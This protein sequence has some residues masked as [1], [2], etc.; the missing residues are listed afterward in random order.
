MLKNIIE[1][2]GKAVFT[3][4][5]SYKTPHVLKTPEQAI[6]G[7]IDFEYQQDIDRLISVQLSIE[8][9]TEIF[10]ISESESKTFGID[11]LRV[12]ILQTLDKN[13]I[14]YKSGKKVKHLYLASYYSTAELSQLK[15]FWN[16]CSVRNVTPKI[17]NVSFPLIERKSKEGVVRGKGRFL[18]SII[19]VYHFFV[20]M[21]TETGKKS[22]EAVANEF[23]ETKELGG[24]MTLEGVGG[25]T[26][27]YWKSHMLEFK[28]KHPVEF[29]KYAL[30]D[31]IITEALL[32]AYR[33]KEWEEL[34]VDL[35]QAPTNGAIA[36]TFFRS[37]EMKEGLKYGNTN[38][39]ARKFILEC[40]HG[41][42]M[43][44]LKRGL[45]ESIFENDAK[46]FYSYSM[47]N[48]KLLPRN[49]E[50]IV[51]A[52]TLKELLTGYDGWCKVKFKFPN[53]F[54]GKKVFPTLPIQKYMPLKDGKTGK[55][56]SLILFPRTGVSYCTVSEIRGAMEFGCKIEFIEGWYYVDGTD[57]FSDFAGKEIALR[58]KARA[59]GDKIGE[60]IHKSLPNHLVGKLFQHRGGFE[61]E[62]AQDIA[63]YLEE[64]LDRVIS[65]KAAVSI[66]CIEE[67]IKE[68]MEKGLEGKAHNERN[69]RK[70]KRKDTR[71]ALCLRIKKN[72]VE[73]T[74]KTRIGACWL[75]EIW[76]LILG[77]A[78]AAL[79][80]V[81]NK[82][83][84]DPVHISTD[85][86]HDVVPLNAEIETPFGMYIFE[87]TGKEGKEMC[88]D[89]TKL[90]TH[91]EKIAQHAVHVNDKPF[92]R[93]MIKD[94][95]KTTY[96][97]TGSNTLRSAALK[98][99]AFGGNYEKEMK[100]DPRWDGK[101]KIVVGLDGKVGY[102]AWESIEEYFGWI[103]KEKEKRKNGK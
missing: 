57:S 2:F 4:S 50:D 97:K 48:S 36:T 40:S 16:K 12:L 55:K 29:E 52:G 87:A 56:T 35:L 30:Q 72:G 67:D 81:I 24:K 5:L 45:F 61:I 102:E 60:A 76:S 8:G 69:L 10:Y 22:L 42:V 88:I 18:C 26:E 33:A 98:G 34:S 51:R 23:K 9:K 1:E 91:G 100:F 71:L 54:E 77:R 66:L 7:S 90:Y 65:G 73:V 82:Y 43:I 17:V 68:R 13:G 21:K 95:V 58:A 79:W 41:A 53:S 3:Q 64:P 74:S 32:R 28:K 93:K 63:E 94:A 19:D 85:S 99:E 15:D 37:Y 14:K 83:A 46:G 75:P 20:D 70:L 89:R 38:I 49:N 62:R 44:A 96:G 31:V 92:V 101:M 39:K 86:Y 6:L 78:R 25:N 84:I 59:R 103:E 27:D 47:Y 80:W 11:E